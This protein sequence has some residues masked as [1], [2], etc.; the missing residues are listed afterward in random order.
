MGKSKKSKEV[1][2]NSGEGTPFQYDPNFDGIDEDRHCTDCCM[3]IFF[4]LF[5]CGMFALLF[6]SIPKSNYKYIY[7]P[8]D[9]R[10]LLCG[11]D[12]SKLNVDNASDLPDLTDRK[13]LFWVRP[14]KPGYSRSFCV[15]ECPSVGLF[16]KSSAM[17]TNLNNGVPKNTN[18]GS[19]DG[20]SYYATIENY[21]Q[22]DE[23]VK[24]FCPYATK[25]MMERCFPTSGAFSDLIES[26]LTQTIKEF[27]DSM[28]AVS[29]VSR[30]V[31]DIYNTWW[32][33]GVC[34]IVSLFLSIF[35]LLFLRCCA[36]VFVWL[37][38]LLSAAALAALTYMCYKQWKDEFGN[39][40]IIESYS[41]GFVSEELNAKVFRVIFWILVVLD[42][43][44]VLL[45]IFLFNRIR[46]SIRIIK[47]VSRIFGNAP[48]LFLFP[49]VQYFILLVWWVYVIGVAIVLFGAG[50]PVRQ[51]VEEGNTVV[52]KIEMQYDK[53]IQGFAIYHFVGFLW[54]SF[55]I[56]ALGEMTVA[57]V[58]AQFY[59]T[60]DEDVKN[61]PGCLVTRSFFRSLRF[62]AG[63]LA[64]GSLI[65][66]IC[67]IIRIVLEY[68]DQKTK[69][70]RSS[71]AT[72]FIK[73]CKCCMWCLEKFLK[74]LNRNAYIMIAI[75]GFNFFKG[76]K[77]AFL[78]IVRNCV[79][80]ATLNW[81]GDF[82]LFLGR[83]FVSAGITAASLWLFKTNDNVQFY[84]VPTVIVF[85]CCYIASGA[86]TG[87]F[88]I[89]I[90]ST[91][92]CFMEDGE[93]NRCHKMYASKK[94]QKFMRKD[95][96]ENP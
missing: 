95:S 67:R 50:T 88:E 76:A 1:D 14:G 61:L 84:I 28:S 96:E 5:I 29:T 57:G 64:L 9:H 35:W 74:Y 31:T 33:I 54:V 55:F 12:N 44:F 81:V 78:L 6:V 2:S 63:S 20:A 51:L 10:G 71:I 30:A 62:H 40:E 46:L 36:P 72:F 69:N 34:V 52:D 42:V 8:T 17:S 24:Y 65:I 60:R 94:L 56:S 92:L 85:V 70:S 3:L 91:F 82:T 86:F 11:Y 68:V 79:R 37:A 89:A 13:Y 66:T 22:P 7:I 19:Y 18:C 4:I 16:S 53:I 25:K 49:V 15:E 83:V 41:F 90:D 39:H 32:M 73:C 59:F 93:R 23:N 45:I 87:I 58:I 47:F 75:H 48:S 77:E 27:G 43:I 21:S 80:V 26:N 38:V